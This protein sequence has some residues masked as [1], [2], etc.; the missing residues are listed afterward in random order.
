VTRFVNTLTATLT[1][2]LPGAA[3]VAVMTAGVLLML[4]FL[5]S[6]VL[7]SDNA[8]HR[9]GSRCS[10]YET[11]ALLREIVL[12]DDALRERIDL[13]RYLLPSIEGINCQSIYEPLDVPG[14][15]S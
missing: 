15:G 2:E 6:A 14:D 9:I 1:S 5:L 4:A 10:Q 13:T 7:G 11:I 3:V 8:D 12:A